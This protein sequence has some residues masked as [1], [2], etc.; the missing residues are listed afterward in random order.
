[1]ESCECGERSK[2]EVHYGK[3]EDLGNRSTDTHTRRDP[4]LENTVVEL[5]STVVMRLHLKPMKPL[6]QLMKA[7]LV[8]PPPSLVCR[9]V[10]CVCV[11]V[12]VSVSRMG[13][14]G[15]EWTVFGRIR[16]ALSLQQQL[17]LSRAG[18][19]LSLQTPGRFPKHTPG[20][21][22]WHFYTLINKT[23]SLLV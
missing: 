19:P 12:C 17:S 23:L 5:W 11:D 7:R 13:G 4:M 20:V 6:W 3:R 10:V 16:F 9:W 18:A 14:G 22:I 21:I 8:S 1:M 15:G 2:K